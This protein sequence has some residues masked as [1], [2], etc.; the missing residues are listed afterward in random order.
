MVWIFVLIVMLAIILIRIGMYSVWL[1]VFS[2][3]LR[4]ALLVMIFLT[5]ALIWRRVLGRKSD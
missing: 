1:A 5:A 3:A 2:G 4:L